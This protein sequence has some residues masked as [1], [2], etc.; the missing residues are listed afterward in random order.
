VFGLKD[1]LAAHRGM[2]SIDTAIEPRPKGFEAHAKFA[3]E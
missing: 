3:T 1:R 2:P